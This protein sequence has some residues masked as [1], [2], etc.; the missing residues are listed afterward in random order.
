MTE[1]KPQRGKF[2][3]LLKVAEHIS[4]MNLSYQD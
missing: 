2:S 4:F 1:V 3:D